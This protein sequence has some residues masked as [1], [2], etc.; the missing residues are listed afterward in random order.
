MSALCVAAVISYGRTIATG[1]R[2]GVTLEQ[3]GRLPEHLQEAHRYFKDYRDKF[4]A[5]SVNAFEE[6]S[7]KVYLVPEERGP[8]AVSSIST[9]HSRVQMLS[10]YDMTGLRDLAKALFKIVSA[11]AELERQAVLS[12]AQSLPIDSLYAADAGSAFD[13]RDSSVSSA[14]SKFK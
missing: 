1:V 13:P 14:R 5:H 6:N 9:Q 4:A 8:R 11:D 12:H 3:I 7:V 10:P 2:S